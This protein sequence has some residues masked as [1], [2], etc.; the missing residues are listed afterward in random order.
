M[1]NMILPMHYPAM[2]IK[3]SQPSLA[4]GHPFGTSQAVAYSRAE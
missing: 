4:I 1:N 2:F 3:A